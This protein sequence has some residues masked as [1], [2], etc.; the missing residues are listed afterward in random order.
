VSFRASSALAFVTIGLTLA[1]LRGP[2]FAQDVTGTLEVWLEPG[3]PPARLEAPGVL[4]EEPPGEDGRAVFL[5]LYPGPYAFHAGGC[6]R[7]VEIEPGR[8]TIV[9]CPVS[10]EAAAEAVRADGTTVRSAVPDGGTSFSADDLRGLPR[11]ADPWSLLRDVPGVVLDRVNV[12]GS[13]SEVQSLLVA[14]GDPGIGASWSV[15]GVEVTDPAALGTSLLYPDMDSLSSFTARTAATD[16]RV[17]APGVHI[18]L[19]LPTPRTRLTGGAHLRGSWD[20]LQSDNLPDDLGGRPFFRNRTESVSELGAELGGPLRGGRAWLFGS[21]FRNALAQET[22]TEHDES[23]RT[24][25]VMAKARVRSGAGT[26]SFLALRGNKVHEERDTGL[27]TAPEARWR[28]S[29]PTWVLAVE[30]QR[31]IRGLSLLSYVSWT[32]GGFGLEPYGGREPSAFQDFRG[33]LQ[34]S[35][36]WLQ[37]DRDR[38][39]LGLEAAAERR[40]F[41]ARNDLSFGA[42]WWRAP[43]V[44]EQAW[45]GNGVLGIEQRGVFFQT[46][47]VTGFAIPFRPSSSS[48]VT[49]GLSLFL[50]DEVRF[51]RWTASVGLRLERLQGE[52]RPS[53]VAANPTFPELLPAVSYDGRGQGVD[54]LDLLPRAAVTRALGTRTLLSVGYGAFAAP[55]GTAETTF[56]NP[57]RDTASVTYYWKDANGDATVQR[58]ELDLVRGRLGSSGFD[59]ARPDEAVS[60][61]LVAADLR[62]PRT[63]ELFL[64]GVRHLGDTGAV[65]VRVSW[66]RLEDALWRPLRNLTLADYVARGTV[67]GELFGEGYAVTY[68]APATTSAIVPGNGRT[69]ANRE[70]YAQDTFAAEAEVRGRLGSLFDGRAWVAYT[71]WRER[72]FDRETAVQDPTTIDAEP[73][74]DGGV[75]VVRPG[76]LGRGDLF[77]GAHFVAGVSL[78]ARLPLGLSSA[79]LLHMREG[80]PVPYFE[81]AS[82]GDPASPSKDVLVTGTLDRYRLPGLVLLD[83]RLERGFSFGRTRLTAALDLFNATNASTRLQLARD[84]ELPAFDRPRELVRPRLLRLALDWRF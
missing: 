64:S 62:T 52:N 29:G 33:V 68:F 4:R 50:S 54:W 51:S 83:L 72:F 21:F 79:A 28:Q 20:G 84:V 2:L 70:G 17:R 60:P 58:G 47:R 35:Y 69:L 11:P 46:F 13:E 49:T 18:G 10:P 7:E 12:G 82:T 74:V 5:H 26:T 37:T 66:R 34:R 38:L 30:D 78:R 43:V 73:L 41:G 14:R 31:Q 75:P 80:F 27:S 15:D 22:F 44:T 57:L 3:S 25:A 61:N 36:S 76:G 65:S 48:A 19:L 6:H 1:P 16:P 32:D 8:L 42:A 23:L 59:P 81:V 55:L 9:R 40:L 67:R 71:D 24:S 53:S 77:V 63:H 56:D 45:P 39:R